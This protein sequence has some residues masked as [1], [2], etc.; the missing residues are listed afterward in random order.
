L[1]HARNDAALDVLKELGFEIGESLTVDEHARVRIRSKD[2]S[3]LVEFGQELW[4]L[5]AGRLTLADIAQRRR[6][7]GL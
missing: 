3:A 7:T 4:E 5:A 1:E 2:N 6:D